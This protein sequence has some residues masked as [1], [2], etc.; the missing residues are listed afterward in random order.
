MDITSIKVPATEAMLQSNAE[1]VG[2]HPMYSPA[3]KDWKGQTIVCC[4]VRVKKWTKW[5]NAMLLKS[6][7]RIHMS[8]PE[9]HDNAMTFVQAVPQFSTLVNAFVMKEMD[10]DIKETRD[11]MSAFYRIQFSLMGRILS[12]DPGLYADILMENPQVVPALRCFI[13]Q[14]QDL[15][16]IVE[17]KDRNAFSRKCGDASRHFGQTN[18]TEAFEFF[19][20]LISLSVESEQSNLV[21]L[22]FT[23]E[24]NKPGLLNRVLEVFSEAQINL[25]Y[26]RFMKVSDQRLSFIIGFEEPKDSPKIRR[27]LAKVQELTGVQ[28]Q[29]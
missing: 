15:L 3:I 24:Q 11:Y 1:V 16:R 6:R 23:G 12:G 28:L 10:V 22:T 29:E 13:A 18:L 2:L 7:A 19:Q 4:K 9:E 26:Q 14:A 21:T 20:R 27:A 17:T 25:D 8:T 5:V